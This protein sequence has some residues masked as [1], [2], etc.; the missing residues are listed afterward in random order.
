M[1]GMTWS[2]TLDAHLD[3]ISALQRDRNDALD[4]IGDFLRNHPE[5]DSDL[6]LT[7]ARLAL[8]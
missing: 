2:A 3:K 1:L 8:L 4:A 5:H 6:C 7:R